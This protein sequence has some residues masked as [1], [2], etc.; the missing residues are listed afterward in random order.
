MSS[1]DLAVEELDGAGAGQGE[2]AALGAVDEPAALAQRPVLVAEA[3]GPDG[4][5]QIEDSPAAR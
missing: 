1:L 3:V 5:H 2:L 4:G